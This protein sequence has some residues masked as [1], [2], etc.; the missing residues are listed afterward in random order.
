MITLEESLESFRSFSQNVSAS[1]PT[2]PGIPAAQPSLPVT[3]PPVSTAHP[4][5]WWCPSRCPSA[6][7]AAVRGPHP[8]ARSS[9]TRLGQHR[10]R[11]PGLDPSVDRQ[12]RAACLRY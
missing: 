6:H 2:P 7:H 4:P 10:R 5:L 9:P 8:S 11:R 1:R 3:H 12:L